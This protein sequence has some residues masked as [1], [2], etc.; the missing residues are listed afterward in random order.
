MTEIMILS[1]PLLIFVLFIPRLRQQIKLN[2]WKNQHNLTRHFPVYQQLYQPI[3]G[4]ALSR[5]ARRMND[6]LEYL[7]GEI[8]FLPFIA[9]LSLTKPNRQT[10]FYDL[11]SGTGKAVIAC[12]M[13]FPV[14]KSC[15]IELFQ[16]L[17]QAAQ[18]R[19]NSLSECS[20]YS[21]AANTVSFIQDN[22]LNCAWQEATLIF[23]N[24]TAF[25]GETWS[26]LNQKL[27]SLAIGTIVITTT[28]P[29]CAGDAFELI[30]TTRV[31]MSWGWV[32]AYIQKRR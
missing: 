12:A 13:V 14:K 19:K 3:N 30:Q 2:R 1:V 32:N 31:E 28:K 4:F 11:G 23:I 20:G 22:F 24:A 9:L 8:E 15:G 27:Q 26:A 17:H 6:A 16:P 21:E 29:L 7:Y 18:S 5:Q 25:I 10:V